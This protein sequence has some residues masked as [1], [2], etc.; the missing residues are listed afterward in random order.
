VA[1]D[2]TGYSLLQYI[3]TNLAQAELFM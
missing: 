2:K 3:L 1:D